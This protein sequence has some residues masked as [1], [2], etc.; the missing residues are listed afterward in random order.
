MLS[1]RLIDMNAIKSTLASGANG[2]DAALS[3]IQFGSF[4]VWD[5]CATP[6]AL[7]VA[8]TTGIASWRQYI[9][10]TDRAEKKSPD[11]KKEAS[12][13]TGWLVLSFVAIFIVCIRIVMYNGLFDDP[14][15]AWIRGL[16]YLF[17]FIA[18]FIVVIFEMFTQRCEL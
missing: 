13:F 1:T 18:L 12:A 15:S 8:V 3:G 5:S 14:S 11:C 6:A 4:N 9:I 2:I 16:I 17:V 7:A 10:D